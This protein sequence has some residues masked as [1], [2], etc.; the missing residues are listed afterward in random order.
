MTNLA[1]QAM[2]R[3]GSRLARLAQRLGA[4]RGWRR[5]GLAMLLGVGATAAFAPIYAVPLLVPA[6]T[7]LVWLHNGT[8]RPRAALALGWSFGF[9]HMA[10]GLS[11]V[12]LAFLVDAERFGAL[13]PVAIGAMAAG[14]A[15]FPAVTLLILHLTK[16]RGPAQVVVLAGA[17]V[18]IEWVRSW[19]FTGFPW[20]LAGTVWSFAPEPMQLAAYGGV[21][22]LSFVTVLAA[23]APAA[24]WPRRNRGGLVFCAAVYGLLVLVWIGGA[25]RLAAAPAPGEAVVEGVRLRLVQA[26]IAQ[27]LKWDPALRR[28]HIHQQMR[29][30]LGPE[31]EKITHVV[32][33]ETAVP[34][35]LD[36]DEDL[37]RLLARAVPPGGALITGAPRGN[38]GRI[39]NSILALDAR[40]DILAIYDKHHLVPFG[41][42]VPFR[43]VL[44]LDKLTAGNIDFTA[45]PGLVQFT[46]P[47]LPPASALICYEVIFPGQVVPNA[48][49][50]PAW[51]LNV[52][53]DAWFGTSLGPFQHFASARMRAVEE[54]LPLVRAANTGI[55][56]VVD[57]YGRLLG[58][59]VLNDVGVVDADLPEPVTGITLYAKFGN[60][61]AAFLIFCAVLCSLI[62][63]RFSQ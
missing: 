56:A 26:S 22:S 48:M 6:F 1:A 14:M 44:P 46:V 55:T 28:E 35:L 20:N 17:W 3:S 7:G 50:R 54:G 43:S 34:Y 39:W 45:G 60:W 23:A 59:L 18:L 58:Q 42:Y 62:L 51:L 24:V 37:R 63:R 33:P 5:H 49:P 12:G 16:L 9:G 41:E 47:G 53:N 21:W 36:G 57:G 38:A 27:T 10:S 31:F 32:W 11:W 29:L 61:P 30:T 13:M 2:D 52:T 25:L 19:I 40:G 4:L 8:D 15:I